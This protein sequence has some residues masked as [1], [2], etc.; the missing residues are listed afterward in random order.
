MANNCILEEKVTLLPR[1]KT[2][3]SNDIKVTMPSVQSDAS[4][5][6]RSRESAPVT[7]REMNQQKQD[8]KQQR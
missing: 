2:N 4:R 6:Q 8:Q 3:Y 1:N 7:K 5:L